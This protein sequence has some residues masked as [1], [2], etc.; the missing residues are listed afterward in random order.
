MTTELLDPPAIV[1]NRVPGKYER[2]CWER[3]ERDL[4]LAAQPGGHPKGYWFDEAAGERVVQFIEQYCCHFEG[5]W[6]GRPL[7]LEDW[8]KGI[9]RIVFGWMRRDG[10]R[11]FR[12]AYI[13]IPRKNGKSITGGGV[14]LF[15]TIA[16]NEAGAQVYATAT[17]RDQAKIVWGAAEAMVKRSPRLR[18]FARAFKNN[19]S[20]ERLASK[21]EPLAADSDTQDGF[22]AHAQ[23]MDEAHAHKDRHVYD[24]VATSMGARRQP[25]NWIIT[26]AGVYN[27]ESIGW[28]MHERAIQVLEG[29]IE[30]DT[31][32]A[33]IACAD[34][35]DDW[36]DPATWAKANPN[37]GISVKLDYLAE[38]CER[39][40]TTPTF[41]NTF[42]R[43]HLNRWTQQDKRWIP[44]EKWNACD[45]VVNEVE[46]KNMSCCAALDLSSKLDIT[47]LVLAF[48]RDED[49]YD[50]VF[51]FWCPEATIMERSKV[52]RIPYDAWVRDGWMISTP[53]DMVDYSFP[54]A[55]IQKLGAVHRIE[56][57]AYDPW[58]ASQTATGLQDLGFNMVEHRQGFVSMSEPTKMLEALI[59]SRKIGH[60]TERGPHPVM[61]WMVS[62][63]AVK[64]DP[65]ENMKPIKTSEKKRIDGVVAA[66][67]ALGR[68]MLTPNGA[69]VYEQRGLLEF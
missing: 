10:T 52:D 62:N 2:L 38:Q 59:M 65:A 23:I 12:T 37:L 27:P 19:I 47:A 3:H 25:I 32:F 1:I 26:T 49:T 54:I 5:E 63:V 41:L 11:R 55:E 48:P 34:E 9:L 53:G 22:N 7:L 69:S 6:A 31:F 39:A 28:E 21:F 67:M 36:E 58:N 35:D 44:I 16:D 60:L 20:C 14:G 45:R 68:S 50:F 8:Q 64:R 4:A 43:Y 66:V 56:E 46:L 57:L 24:V 13:E 33:F 15:L 30:D 18:K 40:R 42:L 51:R 61:R 29:V 17:K